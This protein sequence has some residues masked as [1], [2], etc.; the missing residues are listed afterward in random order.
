MAVILVPGLLGAERLSMV[1]VAC[2]VATGLLYAAYALTTKWLT[3]RARSTTIGLGEMALDA[4]I[5]LPLAVWQVTSSDYQLTRDDIVVALVL[6]VLCTAIPYVLYP[7]GLRRVR[8]EHASI[9]GYLEPVSAPLYALLLLGEVP[10]TAT[11]AG[12]ALIVVAGVLVVLFGA[13]ETLPEPGHDG[14]ASLEP[15][16]DGHAAASSGAGGRRSDARWRR[17]GAMRSR[18]AQGYALV[19]SAFVIMGLIGALVA[20]ASAPESALLVIRFMTAGAV[21][22]VVFARRRPLAGARDR[23]VWPRLLLM[24]FLDAIPLLLFFIAMRLNSVAIGMFLQFMAPVWV[25]LAAPRVFK[26][27]TDFIVYPALLLA[28]AGVAV[29]LAPLLFGESVRLS[30]WG[31]A[32]GIGAGVGYAGF[33]MSIKDLTT[34]ISSVGIV[35]AECVLNVVILLPLALWQTVGAAYELSKVD[36]AAGLLLGVLCTAIAYTMW[37]E[38]VSRIRVQHSSI[39]GYLEPVT[40][41]LYALVLLGQSISSWTI[42]GGALIVLAGLLVVLYGERD[43]V[44]PEPPA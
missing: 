27:R 31:V 44:I 3:R 37:T 10:A 14:A 2:G 26:T 23:A 38:G 18:S 13:G 30:W 33:Q 12:G 43:E 9:L 11:I 32:A 15:A 21:L 19:A 16:A 20:W 25:A 28:L 7:E 17:E 36:L 4:L 5:L 1:G 6:G 22:G 24:G 8:V 29:I 34:R 39:L 42:A 41:P 40:A 35:I